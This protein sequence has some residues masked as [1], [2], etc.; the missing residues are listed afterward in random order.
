M[1]EVR[2]FK[3]RAVIREVVFL[4]DQSA[5]SAPNSSIMSIRANQIETIHERWD[6][7]KP[8]RITVTMMSGFQHIFIGEFATSFLNKYSNWQDEEGFINEDPV[9]NIWLFGDEN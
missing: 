5:Q 9:G 6:K 7:E 2:I 4:S 8:L 1:K 3:D